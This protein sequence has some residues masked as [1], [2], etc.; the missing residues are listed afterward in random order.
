MRVTIQ[1]DMI[2]NKAN[3]IM[4]NI[5]DLYSYLNELDDLISNI[6]VAWRG[7]D[8]LKLVNSMRE[9]YIKETRNLLEELQEYQDYLSNIPKAYEL[10]DETYSNKNIDV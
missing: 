1:N 5:D 8:V 3:S 6:N 2:N 4:T 9:K 10:L 7:N